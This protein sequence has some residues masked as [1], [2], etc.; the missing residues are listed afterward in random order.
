MPIQL[1]PGEIRR[2]IKQKNYD[3]EGLKNLS[4]RSK[5]DGIDWYCTKHMHI[6][7]KHYFF[8]SSFP[9]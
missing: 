1:A 7:I 6:Y 8:S 3:T 5:P 2:D 4:D 9:V